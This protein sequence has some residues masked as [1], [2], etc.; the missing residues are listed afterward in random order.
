MTNITEPPKRHHYGLFEAP[1]NARQLSRH[2]GTDPELAGRLVAYFRPT[3]FCLD[4][5]RGPGPTYPF[6]DAL[7]EPKD[8]C[9]ILAGRDF[10]DWQRPVDW[11]VTNPDWSC[12]YRA[13][14]A[15]AFRVAANVVFLAPLHVAV[16]TYRRHRDWHAHLHGLRKI[17]VLDW[18]DAGFPSAGYILAAI[19]WQ[20]GYNG[21]TDWR[22]W[23][24]IFD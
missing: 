19:H 22:Y 21:G 17:I 13:F 2:R 12:D 3:G 8:W 10:L 4:P 16:N 6:Y 15:H 18:E 1:M 11:I 9:E 5:C 23:T 20:R 24:N 7:P 14:A